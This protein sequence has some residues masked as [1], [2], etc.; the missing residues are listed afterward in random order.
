VTGAFVAGA[1]CEARPAG[2]ELEGIGYVAGGAV[3]GLV[4]GTPT[5]LFVALR[6]EQQGS[7]GARVA[8]MAMAGFLL[9]APVG[10]AIADGLRPTH[11]HTVTYGRLPPE[12]RTNFPPK[13]CKD[14]ELP[15]TLSVQ[16]PTWVLRWGALSG[17]IGAGVFA[18]LKTRGLR[19]EGD[20][21]AASTNAGS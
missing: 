16:D 6:V 13:D 2:C 3:I 14:I 15:Y 18:L 12:C 11:T 20:R 19:R 17:G 21:Q 8:M 1:I 7:R 5:M 10:G 4:V 9:L